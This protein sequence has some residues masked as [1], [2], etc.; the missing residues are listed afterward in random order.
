MDTT[1]IDTSYYRDGELLFWI[2]ILCT[3]HEGKNLPAPGKR[4]YKIPKELGTLEADVQVEIF[5]AIDQD[6]CWFIKLE[7]KGW[8]THDRKGAQ[9]V[10]QVQDV[11]EW[12]RAFDKRDLVD[13]SELL[14]AIVESKGIRNVG[15]P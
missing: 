5:S 1:R 13:G 10:Q 12:L 15:R 11:L 4:V 8:R 3:S 2:Y 6:R 9:E 7:G 14:F